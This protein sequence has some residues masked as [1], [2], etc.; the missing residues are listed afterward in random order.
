M[1]VREF[2][3]HLR[4]ICSNL[5]C[6]LR[7]LFLPVWIWLIS[8]LLKQIKLRVLEPSYNSVNCLFPHSPR[9]F[10]FIWRVNNEL[11]RGKALLVSILHI[12]I[13]LHIQRSPCVGITKRSFYHP[14]FPFSFWATRQFPLRS[15]V[16]FP[17]SFRQSSLQSLP[18]SLHRTFRVF[19]LSIVVLF[20]VF[21]SAITKSPRIRL[22]L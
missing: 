8:K 1:T 9:P 15:V 18:R 12:R 22:R 14:H 17:R 11:Q 21:F 13:H 6:F 7:A 4:L 20:D 3:A 16:A 19:R 5:R 10:Y 2:I